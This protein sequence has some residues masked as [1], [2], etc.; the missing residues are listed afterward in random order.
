[1]TLPTP[2]PT[3]SPAPIRPSRVV[4]LRDHHAT[5]AVMADCIATKAQRPKSVSTLS[6]EKLI[7]GFQ[8]MIKLKNG[9]TSTTTSLANGVSAT[10]A[11]R[12]T[13]SSRTYFEI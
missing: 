10:P 3:I 8:A 4:K 1:M 9:R 13:H 12:I 6:N 5:P 11:G 7:P 2:P